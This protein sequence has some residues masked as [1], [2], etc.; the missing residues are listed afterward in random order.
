MCNV[1]APFVIFEIKK[2]N[3]KKK[4]KEIAAN[5][6]NLNEIPISILMALFRY[7]KK[8]KEEENECIFRFSCSFS[9]A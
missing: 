3:G 6:Q 4:K 1:H 5:K 9:V 7:P 8:E 2:K